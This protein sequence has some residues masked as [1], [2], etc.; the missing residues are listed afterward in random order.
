MM[1]AAR[2]HRPLPEPLHEAHQLTNCLLVGFATFLR[3]SELGFANYAALG[4]AAG[5]RHER[6]W[7]CAEQ[8]D[9]VERASLLI[10]ARRLAADLVLPDV[11]PI[12][13]QVERSF[14]LASVRAT[15]GEPAFPPA[16]EELRIRSQQVPPRGKD[17]LGIGF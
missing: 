2:I 15:A 9:P 16:R 8:I 4:V 17:A 6:G 5:P 3:I 13:V 7:P 11:F 14:E 10:E 12:Q 1:I